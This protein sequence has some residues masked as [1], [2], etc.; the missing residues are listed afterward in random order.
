METPFFNAP[1]YKS[2]PSL[3]S[4]PAIAEVLK[5]FSVVGLANNHILDYGKKGLQDTLD[6][7][8]KLGISTVGAGMELKKNNQIYI[9]EIEGVKIGILALA[10]QHFNYS[11]DENFG[12]F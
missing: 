10:E 9:K 8:K 1:I 3:K 7:F 11:K 4:H 5:D 6:V 12:Q 2:G